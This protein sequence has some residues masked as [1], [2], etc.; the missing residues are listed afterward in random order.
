MYAWLKALSVY[1]VFCTPAGA[2]VTMPHKTPPVLWELPIPTRPAVNI[3]ENKIDPKRVRYHFSLAIDCAERKL[4][5]QET[6]SIM[7][8]CAYVFNQCYC[9][10][11]L[12]NKHKI[13]LSCAHKQFAT[14]IHMSFYI[15]QYTGSMIYFEI[16]TTWKEMS[17][18]I[19]FVYQRCPEM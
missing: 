1:S 9:G 2:T 5:E 6:F 12:F 11:Y 14:R 16:N 10:V 15:S 4:G 13:T 8:S 17:H 18:S 7:D 19:Q 3:A